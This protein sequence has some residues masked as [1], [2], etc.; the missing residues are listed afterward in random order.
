M[1]SHVPNRL[2]FAMSLTTGTRLGQY[3]ILAPLARG[4]MG[5]VYRARDTRLAR[6]VAIKILK[7]S[8]ART[9]DWI[10]RFER[11]ARLLAALN[12][13]NIAI[14]HGLEEAEGTSFLVMELVPGQT[15]AERLRRGM[16]PHG[17]TLEIGI[18]IALAHGIGP[19]AWDHSPRS[20]ARERHDHAG[21][22]GQGP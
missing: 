11:E 3:E 6:E 1:Q 2:T 7:D 12:H 8:H 4:G 22:Q 18:Q 13:T 5:E 19:R 10:S 20:Q 17:E 9:P 16:L 14:I 21:R 15:L